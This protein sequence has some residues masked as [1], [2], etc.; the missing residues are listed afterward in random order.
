MNYPYRNIW[1]DLFSGRAKELT[2]DY[3]PTCPLLF[4]YGA[5]KPFPFHTAAWTDHVRRTGGEVVE[6]PSGHWVMRDPAF[7]PL[8]RGWLEKTAG[9]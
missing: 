5:D 4:V 3:W 9:A 7:I 1:G 2:R 6:L 8:L